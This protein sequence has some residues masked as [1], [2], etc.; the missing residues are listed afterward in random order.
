MDNANNL[1][2]TIFNKFYRYKIFDSV[3][4]LVTLICLKRDTTRHIESLITILEEIQH[5]NAF[6]IYR[7]IYVV[8][9]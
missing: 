6:R 1:A 8:K 4:S 9:S 2:L 7:L 5:I 3:K